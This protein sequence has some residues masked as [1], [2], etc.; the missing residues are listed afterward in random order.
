M[1]FADSVRD[2]KEIFEMSD[3]Y[4]TFEWY[5]NT[6]IFCS[7]ELLKHDIRENH[8]LYKKLFCRYGIKSESGKEELLKLESLP[9]GRYAVLVNDNELVSDEGIIK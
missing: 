9:E 6:Y 5:F 2:A 1:C 7:C 3:T 4:I 8:D